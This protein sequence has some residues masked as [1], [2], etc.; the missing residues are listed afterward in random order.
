LPGRNSFM[1]AHR[2]IVIALAVIVA[3]AAGIVL[4]REVARRQAAPVAALAHGT[5]IEPPRPLPS[6]ALTDQT[7]TPL[8]PERLKDRWTFVFFGFTHCPD[9]CPIALSV[10]AQVEQSLA[11]LPAARRPQLLFVSVDP[12]RDTPPRMTEYLRTFAAPIVGATGE[13]SQVEVLTRHMAIPVAIRDGGEGNYGVDHSG[14]I[15]LVDPNGGLRA[16]FSTPHTAARLSEDYRR[17]VTGA[18]S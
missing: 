1:S 16:L 14:A 2:P 8:G 5:L 9:I 6:F 15:F 10:L 11:D 18:A 13:P 3:I 7:G 17:L 4:S 12:Q